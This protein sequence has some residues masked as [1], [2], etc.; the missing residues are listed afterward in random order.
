MK[1]EKYVQNIFA[2]NL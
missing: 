1:S 2:R